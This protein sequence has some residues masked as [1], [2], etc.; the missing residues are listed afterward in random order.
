MSYPVYEAPTPPGRRKELVAIVLMA[1]SL[2]IIVSLHSKASGAVGDLLAR[3]LR[4]LFG[5]SADVPA[6]FLFA[7]GIMALKKNPRPGRARRA[8]AAVLLYVVLLSG[9]HLFAVQKNSPGTD[10]WVV[11]FAR[12][13]EGGGYLGGLIVSQLLKAFGVPGSIVVLSALFLVGITLYLET[14]IAKVA[15]SVAQV[16]ARLVVKLSGGIWAFVVGVR[17]EV[18]ELMSTLSDRRRR[19][20]ALQATPAVQAAR[21][22]KRTSVRQPRRRVRETATPEVAPTVEPLE[23]P[24][25]PSNL[26]GGNMDQMAVAD[27]ETI[28]A[29]EP[30][31]TKRPRRSVADQEDVALEVNQPAAAIQYRLPDTALLDR[32]KDAS[33]GRKAQAVDQSQLLEETLATFGVQA[34]VVQVSRGPVVTRYELQPAPGVKVSRIVNLADDVSLNLAAAGV[35]IEAPVPGKSVVGIE[36][37]NKEPSPVYFREVVESPEFRDHPSKL[38]V[39]FGKDIAGQPV[40]ADMTKLL[41]LLIAGATGSGKS[42]C[43]NT[44]I[45]SIL[46]K[47][48][49]DEVKLLMIDPKRVELAVYD[50]IPHLITP[51]VTDPKLA[52]NALRWAVKEMEQRYKKFS[53]NAVRNIDGYNKAVAAGTIEDEPMPYIV[54]I[55]DELADLMLVAGNDVED[56][57][58]RL[59][60]MARAAGIHLVI[61][62][63]RPS[64]DVITGL[65]K[66]NVPSRLSFAVSSGVDSR[67]IL[68]MMGAERLIG[69]GDMLYYP[70]G[71]VKPLRAQGALITDREV[72]AVVE[73]WKMQGTPEFTENVTEPAQSSATIEEGDDEL[74]DDAVRL[75]VETGNASISMIQRRFRVGYARAARLIDMMELAGIVG[76][77]QGS[78]PREVL[79]S[80]EDLEQA[81]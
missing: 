41:H 69:K 75:V 24:A 70:I 26:N 10:Y 15:S 16:L 71:A 66:A 42:V 20:A 64:V 32:P 31:K 48:T 3:S 60:Q 17:D 1:F 73:S 59:A 47:A 53:E 79:K 61:A 2:L 35:R 4:T 72:Q 21:P 50:G 40:V 25:E 38:A 27:P 13:G 30:V 28:D 55:I 11:H 34:K 54:V 58:C 7:A 65:I 46:Y 9:Y 14:P 62:T 37:P 68:D 49:P 12:E 22:A 8:F 52:S 78:K 6:I 33:R 36:V 18:I 57:I 77:Y 67:T 39:A 74:F 63:Q 81:N 19:A 43:I 44:L 80:L 45:C 76:P 23:A 56:S 51:V 5:K 29:P